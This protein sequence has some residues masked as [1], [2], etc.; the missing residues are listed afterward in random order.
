MYASTVLGHRSSYYYYDAMYLIHSKV[1]AR[2]LFAAYLACVQQRLSQQARFETFN[3]NSINLYVLFN[4]DIKRK[5]GEATDDRA[6]S[7]TVNLIR[8][9]A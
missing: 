7:V 5:K 3:R 4:R 9:T 2:R 8:H 1:Q 6:V